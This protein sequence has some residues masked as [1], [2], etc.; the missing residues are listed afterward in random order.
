M[1]RSVLFPE[2]DK[3]EM[4]ELPVLSFL[5]RHAQGNVLFDTG[6]HPSVATNP[7]ERWGGLVK[8]M[9]PVSEPGDDVVNNLERIGFATGD[10]DVVIC[11]HFHPDH[12]GCNGF[13][14]KATVICHSRELEAAREQGAEAQAYFPSEWDVGLPMTTIDAEYDVFG[15]SRVVVIP[16]PGHT[17]GTVAA[18]VTLDKAGTFLLAS[19][20]VPTQ[21]NLERDIMP[22]NTRDPET[23]HKSWAEIRRIKAR[24]A[25]VVCGHDD[26]QASAMKRGAEAYD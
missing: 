20:S 8:V 4:M 26:T 2:A 16:V 9:Q 18:L 22:K 12:C 3:S 19:D 23:A 1:R 15:D 11:S 5:I 7:E 17:P 6:C 10:I 21:A 14:R 13:F 25:T 24:G